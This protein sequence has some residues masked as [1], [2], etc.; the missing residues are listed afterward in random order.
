MNKLKKKLIFDYL[1]S[2]SENMVMDKNLSTSTISGF[3]GDTM[4]F[5]YR[6]ISKNFRFNLSDLRIISMMFSVDEG[7][8]SDLIKEYF[9]EKLND[10]NVIMSS[11]L[12]FI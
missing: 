1:D 3:V 9:S 12:P 2:I 11:F 8:A 6:K 5:S 7:D 10:K 4:I